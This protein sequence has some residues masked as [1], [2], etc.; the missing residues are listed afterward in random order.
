MALEDA[1]QTQSDISERKK[2]NKPRNKPELAEH[3]RSEKPFQ[4]QTTERLC[5]SAQGTAWLRQCKRPLLLQTA[6]IQDVIILVLVSCE[7]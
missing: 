3:Q 4:A 1:V 5:F 2:T 7:H 6:R